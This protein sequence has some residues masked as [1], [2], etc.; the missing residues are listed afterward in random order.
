MAPSG[1]SSYTALAA[2]AAP[3]AGPAIPTPPAGSAPGNPAGRLTYIAIQVA[4]KTV[5]IKKGKVMVSLRCVATRGKT[6]K[7][8]VCAG[9]FKLKVGG[10]VLSHKF[11]FKSGKIAHIQVTLPKRVRARAASLHRKHRK[12]IGALVISTK[13][14][15]GAARITYGKLTIRT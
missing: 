7:G 14:P 12:L 2:W 13:Q 4:P 10:R 11:R 5:S 6:K 3:P 8:K 15:T 9:R 1:T